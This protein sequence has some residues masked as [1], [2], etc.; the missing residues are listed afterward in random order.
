MDRRVKQK[1]T[2]FFSHYKL[3]TVKK[4]EIL[5]QA[6]STPFFIFYIEDGLVKEYKVSRKGTETVLN[7]FKPTSF[8]S[9]SWVLTDIVN[10]YYYEALTDLVIRKVP[11]KEMED[12]LQKNSDIALSLLRRIYTGLD[13]MFQHIE[14]LKTGDAYAKLLVSLMLFAKRFGKIEQNEIH[15]D[16]RLTENELASYAGLAR[17]TV[18]RELSKLAQQ[19]LVVVD[20]H[21]L[22]IKDITA[23]QD[24]LSLLS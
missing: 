9:M 3:L 13:G 21:N 15:I 11:K 10:T 22:I 4:G 18:S 16:L 2:S 20:K 17:E 12:F 7:Y 1:I 6:G 14:Q 23:F 5:A 8:F 19:G 24:K